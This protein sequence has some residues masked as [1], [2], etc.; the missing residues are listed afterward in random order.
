MATA[1]PSQPKKYKQGYFAVTN[2]S[3]YIANTQDIVYRSSLEY[4]FCMYLDNSENVLKWGSEVVKIPYWSPL[5]NKQHMYH[6]DFYVEMK[7]PNHPAGMERLLVEVKPHDE[8]EKVLKGTPPEK[9][10]KMTPK[11]I[12]NYEYALREYVRNRQKWK[13]AEEFCRQRGMKFIIV[14]EKILNQLR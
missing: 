13:Y 9:P 12:K 8:A 10:K 4:K 14:T 1:R 2:E 3:K 5:D 6:M 11:A 7:N